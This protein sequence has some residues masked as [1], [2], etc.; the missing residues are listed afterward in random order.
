[1]SPDWKRANLII[2]GPAFVIL[3]PL[4]SML[5]DCLDLGTTP[6]QFA[7]EDWFRN[8]VGSP[9]D[10]KNIGAVCSPT[11][12]MVHKLFEGCNL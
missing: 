9:I 2:D 3:N 10:A 4:A 7:K 5:E 8:L 6:V 12:G 1:M 11:P